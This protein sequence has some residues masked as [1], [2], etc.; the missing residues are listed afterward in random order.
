MIQRIQSVFLVLSVICLIVAASTVY[1]V[2]SNNETQEAVNLYPMQMVHLQLVDGVQQQ[3]ATSGNIHLFIL[4]LFVA[5]ILIF[6][7]FQFKN[8]LRQMQLGALASMLMT[9]TMVLTAWRS[10]Q[11]NELIETTTYEFPA[12]GFFALVGTML[13][14]ISSNRFIRKDEK[15]VKSMDRIR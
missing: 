1:W 11:M 5:G 14:N 9:L 13:F 12:A 4:P 3:V 10:T 15:L 8:R 7:I 2:K 6:S